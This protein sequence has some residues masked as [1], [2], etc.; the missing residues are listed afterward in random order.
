MRTVHESLTILEF[1]EFDF[2]I[3]Y[4]L[5]HYQAAV[6]FIDLGDDIAVSKEVA[7]MSLQAALDELVDEVEEYVSVDLT[8]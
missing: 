6:V 3:T 2:A 5:K 7:S 4:S 1:Y 8:H